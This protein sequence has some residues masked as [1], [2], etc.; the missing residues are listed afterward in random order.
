LLLL[1]LA[2]DW[3]A[4]LDHDDPEVRERATRAL[5]ELG[6]C[7]E[8]ELRARL[9][10]GLPPEAAGRIRGLLADIERERRI[11]SFPGGAQVAGLRCA[12]RLAGGPEDASRKLS[13]EVLNAGS[14]PR[15]I[16]LVASWNRR[17]PGFWRSSAGAEAEIR[18]TGGPTPVR[19]W[20][21][22][23]SV[24]GGNRRVD[25]A[26]LRPGES[27]TFEVDF[28][29][30]FLRPGRYRLTVAYLALRDLEGRDEDVLSN[31]IDFEVGPPSAGM[32]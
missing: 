23:S 16:A 17:V 10:E 1:L 20:A 13:L 19:R 12:V 26:T 6:D 18:V 21:V 3:I 29:A 28:D 5:R 7:A 11:A 14:G 8:P 24:C 31:T 30:A 4:D 2:Q 15:D 27:R 25:R 9:A 22:S 32:P